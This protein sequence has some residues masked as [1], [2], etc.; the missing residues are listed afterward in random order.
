[1]KKAG[2]KFKSFLVHGMFVVVVLLGLYF[3]VSS[4]AHITGHAVLDAATAKT[5]LETAL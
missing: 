2:E 1:M 4:T 5:K 3:I